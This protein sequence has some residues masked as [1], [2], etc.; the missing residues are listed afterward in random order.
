MSKAAR[1][2]PTRVRAAGSR[3]R[4]VRARLGRR[5]NPLSDSRSTGTG[6]PN[7]SVVGA[8][9]QL[10]APLLLGTCAIRRRGLLFRRYQPEG[11]R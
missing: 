5:A 6:E 4:Y 10:P 7:I 9:I 2:Q 1:F 8:A 3:L 11:G